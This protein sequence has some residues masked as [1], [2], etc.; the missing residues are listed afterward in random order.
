LKRFDFETVSTSGFDFDCSAC[1]YCGERTIWGNEKFRRETRRQED[2]TRR[3][4]KSDSV[5]DGTA[6]GDAVLR[7]IWTGKPGDPNPTRSKLA[8]ATFNTRIR[9]GEKG[10]MVHREVLGCSY[11]GESKP[12]RAADGQRWGVQNDLCGNVQTMDRSIT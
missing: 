11:G 8:N 2:E 12:L 10:V 1:A 9:V 7:L 4:G 5:R 3:R 6:V